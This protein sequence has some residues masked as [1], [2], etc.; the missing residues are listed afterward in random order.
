MLT[1]LSALVQR[2]RHLF[3]RLATLDEETVET[4]EEMPPMVE[5]TVSRR[6]MTLISDVYQLSTRASVVEVVADVVYVRSRSPLKL[7]D[8]VRTTLHSPAIGT[9]WFKVVPGRPH[10]PSPEF[11]LRPA[12]RGA[13]QVWFGQRAA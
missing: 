5:S 2:I 7:G 3:E 12:T 13:A 6:V 4:R 1:H 9:V 8:L 10:H 11:G